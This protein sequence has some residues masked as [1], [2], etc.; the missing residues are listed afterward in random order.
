MSNSTL[1]ILDTNIVLDLLLFQD[2]RCQPLHQALTQGKVQW[3]ATPH[4]RNE[5]ERVLTYAHISVKL[6]FYQKS[7][8]DILALFDRYSQIVEAPS[9]RAPFACKDA[10]DQVFI[11]LA[12]AWADHFSTTPTSPASSRVAVSSTQRAIHLLSKDKAVLSMRKRLAKLSIHVNT[13][14]DW[15]I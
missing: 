13:A 3:I 8:S 2:P 6:E 10:D 5:L 15:H 9:T 14:Q 4:M 1:L 12:A 11:D 7:S